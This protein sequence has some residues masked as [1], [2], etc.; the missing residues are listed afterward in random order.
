MDFV[1]FCLASFKKKQKNIEN[2]QYENNVH[3][4]QWW[5]ITCNTRGKENILAVWYMPNIMG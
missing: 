4:R 2:K 1:N 3:I 5:K